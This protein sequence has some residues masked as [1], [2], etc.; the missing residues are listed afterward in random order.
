MAGGAALP[1]IRQANADPAEMTFAVIA[2]LCGPRGS[3]SRNRT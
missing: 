3:P 2:P 1:L